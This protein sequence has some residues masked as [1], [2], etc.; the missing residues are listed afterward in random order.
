MSGAGKLAAVADRL[1]AA[2]EGG[3]TPC[4]QACAIQGG[5]VVHQSSH[6][7]LPS[8]KPVR[9][10]T[11]FDIASVTKVMATTAL[12]GI[13]IHRGQLSFD[14]PVAERWSRREARHP[15]E[16]VASLLGHR[17]GLPAWEPMFAAV[18]GDP[19]ASIIY[20]KYA[21]GFPDDGFDRSRELMLRQLGAHPG[22]PPGPRVY[23]DLG[24]MMLGE[25]LSE[26]GGGRLEEQVVGEVL[27]PLGLEDTAYRPLPGGFLGSEGIV[28]TGELRPRPPAP[29]QAGLFRESG[30]S[31]RIDAGAVDDDNAFAL[32]GVAGHAGLFSTASDVARFGWAMYEEMMGRGRLGA[33]E[34]FLRLGSLDP[35][36]SGPDRTLGFDV[37]TGP[38]S[39]AGRYLG[40]AG[41]LGA[42]GHLGFTGCS[43]WI[44][45]D[46]GVSVALLT[47]R[48]F[49]GR[50]RVQGIRDLR[51]EF[52]DTLAES[53]PAA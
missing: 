29:G 4:A 32:G 1:D 44:D 38:N 21:T 42:I 39:T 51:R 8:G 27:T 22:G 16:T 47:N 28:P 43:L 11:R 36:G 48:T 15:H 6:G 40:T 13:L 20:S 23:S 26:V 12:A 46:R 5:E 45:R 25:L 41:P 30:L 18:Q 31:P 10:G 19:A 2:V 3:V 49:F 35:H 50:E 17:S 52:H 14:D 37:P 7:V 33:Q 24:F 34:T 53:L 9:D